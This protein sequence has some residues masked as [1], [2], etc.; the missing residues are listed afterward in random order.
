[1]LIPYWFPLAHHSLS[2]LPIPILSFYA[3]ISLH[4]TQTHSFVTHF[5]FIISL[6]IHSSNLI[7]SLKKIYLSLFHF[8][9]KPISCLHVII[10][11]NCS[12][13]A[14]YTSTL[15][16][17]DWSS[18]LPTIQP[19]HLYPIQCSSVLINEPIL[20]FKILYSLNLSSSHPNSTF[21]LSL[22]K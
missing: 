13:S 17:L 1:M 8:A 21:K 16:N 11:N 18:N 15:H 9:K 6:F 2:V 10:N 14:T 5:T 20:T 19:S 12:R 3:I 22:Q 4:Y 7:S